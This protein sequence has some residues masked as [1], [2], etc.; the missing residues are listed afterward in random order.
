M[1]NYILNRNFSL[2]PEHLNLNHLVQEIMN[3]RS[4]FLQLNKDF[5]H[6]KTEER[7]ISDL[8]TNYREHKHKLDHT[9]CYGRGLSEELAFEVGNINNKEINQTLKSM[10]NNLSIELTNRKKWKNIADEVR[11]YSQTHH[12]DIW[13]LTFMDKSYRKIFQ[14]IDEI[15]EQLNILKQSF[16]YQ[17]Q[18]NQITTVEAIKLMNTP[19]ISIHGNQNQVQTGSNNQQLIN[20]TPNILV[21]EIFESLK[22]FISKIENATLEDKTQFQAQIDDLKLSYSQPSFTS[23]Y[24]TFM[25]NVSAHVT[26]GAALWQSS[27]MPL[28]TACLPN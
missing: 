17:I 2:V 10:V 24:S 16:T 9:Y 14:Y 1:E 21:P 12:I 25:S 18:S 6:C 8:E 5:V 20:Q 7:F 3:Y 15:L 4:K 19:N 26:I 11:E 22:T 28:L 23:K 27:L 13:S